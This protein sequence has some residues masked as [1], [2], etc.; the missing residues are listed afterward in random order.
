M[1][2]LNKIF[3]KKPKRSQQIWLTHQAQN[4]GDNRAWIASV[5][6][7]VGKLIAAGGSL[8]QAHPDALLSYYLNMYQQQ[9]AA[10]GFNAF[11]AANGW[12]EQLN[13]L[14]AHALHI[15]DAKEHLAHFQNCCQTWAISDSTTREQQ[16]VLQAE[17]FHALPDSDQIHA[18]WLRRHAHTVFLSEAEIDQA[19]ARLLN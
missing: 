3:R 15:C 13:K 4:S 5:S 19:I 1:N 11:V 16:T 14:I 12:N 9:A 18:A 2:W 6:E 17:G 10:G 7:N 8:A